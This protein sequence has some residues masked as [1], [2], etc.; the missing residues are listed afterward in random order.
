VEYFVVMWN[1]LWPFG[2]HIWAFGIFFPFWYVWINKNL[3]ILLSGW[4]N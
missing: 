3:A 2:M 1:I 4:L